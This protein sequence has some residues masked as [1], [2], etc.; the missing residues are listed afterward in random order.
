MTNFSLPYKRAKVARQACLAWPDMIC[1]NDAAI[2]PKD[3]RNRQMEFVP[4]AGRTGLSKKRASQELQDERFEGVDGLGRTRDD[5]DGRDR[6]RVATT[7]YRPLGI[8]RG[9]RHR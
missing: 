6:A 7:G 1:G 4:R 2:P 8:H 5:G 9:F 3:R